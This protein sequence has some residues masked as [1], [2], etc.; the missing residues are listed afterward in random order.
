MRTEIRNPKAEGRKKS[1]IRNPKERRCRRCG[2]THGKPCVNKATGLECCWVARDLCS[3]CLTK[4]ERGLLTLSGTL[5]VTA[6]DLEKAALHFR[7]QHALV[8]AIVRRVLSA[9]AGRKGGR[10]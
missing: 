8:R 6:L 1:E 9:D 7:A 5:H 3:E 2:C 4:E 10:K